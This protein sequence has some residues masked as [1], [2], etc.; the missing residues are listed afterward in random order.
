[1]RSIGFGPQVKHVSYDPEAPLHDRYMATHYPGVG[2]PDFDTLRKVTMTINSF[3]GWEFNSC[4]SLRKDGVWYPMD[5]ANACP[6]SQVTSLHQHFPWLVKSY[7]RWS[8][9][10]AATKKKMR[11]TLD[12]EPFFAARD[13][14][15]DLREQVARYAKIARERFE[16]ARFEEF[17]AKHLPHLDEVAWTYFGSERAKNA[18][19]AKV[20]MLFPRHEWERFTEHFF[21]EIQKWR[22]HDAAERAA[23][24]AK[25]PAVHQ[26]HFVPSGAASGTATKPAP[27]KGDKRSKK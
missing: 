25:G 5:F 15:L 17:C 11:A 8:L 13:E 2:D 16:S 27:A 4:E 22:E 1:V 20:K 14:K 21:G 26:H 12:W 23:A 19:A 7:I 24:K 10:C 18:V 6:D 9:Y 3:F